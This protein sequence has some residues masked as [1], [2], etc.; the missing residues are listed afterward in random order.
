[1]AP[2]ASDPASLLFQRFVQRGDPDALTK[3][4]DRVGPELLALASHLAPGGLAAE[5][6][7]QECFLTAIRRARR[8]NPSRPVLPWLAGIL[9]RE[10]QSQRRRM[11]RSIDESRLE[12]RDVPSGERL[13]MGAELRQSV[14]LALAELPPRY[15]EVVAASLLD[16]E[17]APA[18]ARRLRRAPGTVRV[19]LH[20]GL[21]MLRRVLPAGIGL[22]LLGTWVPRGMAEVRRA[23]QAEAVLHGPALAAA[24][25]AVP[26]STVTWVSMSIKSYALAALAAAVVGLGALHL[27]STEP[28]KP[29]TIEAAGIAEDLTPPPVQQA[30]G[31]AARA[32]R[33]SPVD[34]EPAAAPEDA[35]ALAPATARAAGAYL[36]GTVEAKIQPDPTLFQLEVR[37]AATGTD[38][39]TT[40]LLGPG[41]FE[42]DLAPLL[43]DQDPEPVRVLAIVRAEGYEPASAWVTPEDHP[44]NGPRV[45]RVALRPKALARVLSG[46]V[47]HPRGM[48]M[49]RPWVGFVPDDPSVPVQY[50]RAPTDRLGTD[51]FFEL[52]LV[53]RMAGTLLYTDDG[54]AVGS[55]RVGAD[56]EAEIDVGDL[57]L[58][59]GATIEGRAFQDGIPMGPG[60]TVLALLP[61][62]SSPRTLLNRGI[63][64]AGK[65]NAALLT[66]G[67]RSV[68][69]T[70]GAAGAFTLEGLVAGADYFLV[71]VPHDPS[72]DLSHVHRGEDAGQSV[73]A[74]AAGVELNWG[75]KSLVVRAMSE[76][77]P[78]GD[79]KV[80]PAFAPGDPQAG[81]PRAIGSSGW[82]IPVPCDEQ[83]RATLLIAAG[84]A[85]YVEVDSPSHAPHLLRLDPD[86]LPDGLEIE[87]ELAPDAEPASLR[88]ELQGASQE[89]L[90]GVLALVYLLEESNEL[91][92]RGWVPVQDGTA[93]FE[94]ISLD[95]RNATL[96]LLLP[97][98]L[99]FADLPYIDSGSV[100]LALGDLQSGEES[101]VKV[102]L[103]EGGRIELHLVGRDPALPPSFELQPVEGEAWSPDLLAPD[104][105]GHDR[106]DAISHDGPY[107]LQSALNPGTYRLRQTAS[108][109]ALEDIEV[110]VEAGQTSVVTFGLRI[111]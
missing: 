63:G 85:C 41:P 72:G 64:I 43:Q 100:P 30:L 11:A 111:E 84:D 78:V 96:A 98:S 5:D 15:R 68:E 19:Q 47:V 110:E 93:V 89:D 87:V 35:H 9:I 46:R 10:A 81:L 90:E 66:A 70:V 61:F 40:E 8:W 18:I 2:A 20:R 99:P 28:V 4:F 36:R 83:G 51:G 71:G 14:E 77:A 91:E 80:R 22:G 52:R 97:Q 57:E 60:S 34:L 12:P 17:D 29:L 73:R 65:A 88:V 103:T 39:I 1:M 3:L 102:S 95:T 105:R 7:V 48:P 79:A 53:H 24:G 101:L 21:E 23:I 38:S 94:D 25:T 75:F 58:Q 82:S 109:Y 13:A 92:H 106:A 27:S 69:A 16:G 74:P 56:V 42:V 32:R 44:A 31:Q 86:A 108:A 6:L 104:P 50:R 49:H 67:H 62:Q 59:A 26:L 76:G 55:H 33:E 107:Y 45:F 37:L 54:F